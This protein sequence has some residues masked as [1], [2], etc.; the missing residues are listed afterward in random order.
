MRLPDFRNLV[1]DHMVEPRQRSG[2]HPRRSSDERAPRPERRSS[3][4]R[5]SVVAEAGYGRE[6]RR[7]GPRLVRHS[8]IPGACAKIAHH[9]SGPAV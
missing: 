3:T 4:R 5:L 9:A 7:L 8:H 6:L 2:V 1:P